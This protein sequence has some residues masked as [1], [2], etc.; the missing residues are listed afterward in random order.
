LVK[1]LL[2]VSQLAS[3][4]GAKLQSLDINPFLLKRRGGIA[5]DALVVL[6]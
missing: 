5:L 3:D 1:A 4:A 2:A 6:A